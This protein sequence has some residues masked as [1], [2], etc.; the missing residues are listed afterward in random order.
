[1]QALRL[2]VVESVSDTASEIHLD[3]ARLY[4]ES[5][6]VGDI[7]ERNLIQPIWEELRLGQLNK[8]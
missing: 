2:E 3:K 1:M 8:L 5:P 4:A 6:Q 7:V